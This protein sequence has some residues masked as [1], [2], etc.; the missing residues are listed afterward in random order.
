MARTYTTEGIW[1]PGVG[2]TEHYTVDGD[3]VGHVKPSEDIGAGFGWMACRMGVNAGR[4]SLRWFPTR[5]HAKRWISRNIVDG[6]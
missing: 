4:R 5:R 2:R 3:H 6:C 1:I